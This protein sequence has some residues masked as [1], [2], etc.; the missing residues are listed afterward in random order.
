MLG[1]FFVRFLHVYFVVGSGTGNLDPKMNRKLILIPEK[2]FSY[3]FEVDFSLEV[4]NNA[5]WGF[6][7]KKIPKPSTF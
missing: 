7:C 4:E 5:D 6:F 3:S 2:I 1:R